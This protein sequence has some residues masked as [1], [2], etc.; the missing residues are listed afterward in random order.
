MR[1]FPSCLRIE[2]FRSVDRIARGNTAFIGGNAC[3]G[4]RGRAGSLPKLT[5]Y[6][7]PR[8]GRPPSKHLR[9]TKTLSNY[10]DM[11][12]S[13]D[14]IPDAAVSVSLVYEALSPPLFFPTRL[15]A[16]LSLGR[17]LFVVRFDDDSIVRREQWDK[18]ALAFCFLH[19]TL[20]EDIR[21][22]Q[23]TLGARTQAP[24]VWGGVAAAYPCPPP[25]V[26]SCP[27]D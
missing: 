1:I 5:R 24:N 9:N 3:S 21:Y 2:N 23:E 18:S 12:W 17:L 25:R 16:R 20:Q 4:G 19:D 13:S 7:P 15:V 11:T 6:L 26:R 14:M 22:L 10:S 27:L 8:V